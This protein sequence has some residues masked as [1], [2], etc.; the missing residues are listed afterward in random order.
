[1]SANTDNFFVD[2]LTLG[3]TANARAIKKASSERDAI[4]KRREREKKLAEEELAAV[5][6]AERLRDE[7]Y[8]RQQKKAAGGRRST[9]MSDAGMYQASHGVAKKEMVGGP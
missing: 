8:G 1:M 9:V 5:D 6:A 2:V 3:G 4:M 7:K